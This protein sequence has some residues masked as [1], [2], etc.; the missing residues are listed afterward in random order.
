MNEIMNNE[1]I[2]IENMI[3]EIDGKEVMLDSDLAKLYHVETKRINEAVKNNPK[4]FP[5]RISW[6]LDDTESK[7]FLVENFDQKQE[8]RGG[9]YKN[10]RVFTEQGVYMLATILK[11][12]VAIEVSIK[13][14]DTFVKMRHY[15]NYN[16]AF[17]P[18]KF[19]LLEDKVERNIASINEL[20]NRFDSKDI[21]KDSIFYEGQCYDAY[22]FLVDIFSRAKEQLTIIDNFASKELLDITK[23]LNLKKITIVTRN[24]NTIPINKYITQ[25]KNVEFVQNNSF[26]DRFIII[27]DKEFYMCGA[28]FKDIG[29]KCFYIGKIDNMMYLY[30]ILKEIE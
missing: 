2:D 5:E 25:Y 16:N 18:H 21:A 17:L 26:H 7:T 6:K 24:I 4:K 14:M 3:Y 13:I 28:S 9:K 23:E 8:T 22:S 1:I 29:K 27:D 15:L 12:D 10:P 19:M 20:F 11:S 30:N